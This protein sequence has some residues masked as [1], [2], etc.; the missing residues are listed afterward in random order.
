M[1]ETDKIILDA[2]C[3]GRMIW[4]DKKHPKT[5]YIDKRDGEFVSSNGIKNT[6][7]PDLVADFT[8]LPFENNTFKL[9]AFD[10]P[11]RT[12]L[13]HN[14]WM[15]NQYGKL[16]PT[17][18]TDLKAGFDECMRVLQPDGVLIFKWNEKQIKTKKIIEI[19]GKE[20]LFGNISGKGGKT[21]WMTFMK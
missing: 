5:L 2:C 10:P 3:G 19:L 9:I 15:A 4:Y 18:E 12:D 13:G 14:S 6:V 7:K 16:L 1:I 20:P 8:S 11:H 17:W 21:I